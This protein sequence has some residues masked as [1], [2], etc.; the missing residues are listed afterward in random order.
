MAERLLHARMREAAVAHVTGSSGQLPSSRVGRDD[1]H[2]LGDNVVYMD[3]LSEPAS[4]PDANKAMDEQARMNANEKEAAKKKKRD[5]WHKDPYALPELQ[6]DLNKITAQNSAAAV[7]G[8]RGGIRPDVRFATEGE[9]RSLLSSIQPTDLDLDSEFF[10]SLPAELQYELVGDLRAASRGTSY[11]RLQTMLAQ[12]PT[13]IDFSRAQ[14]AGLKTRNELTQKV[15]EV[16]DE[17]GDAHIKV[18]IRVAGAR[19]REYVLVR[20]KGDQ[21]G[22]VLGIREHGNTKEKPISVDDDSVSAISTDDDDFAKRDT[23]DEIELEEID[24]QESPQKRPNQAMSEFHQANPN[25]P[26]A[27]RKVAH[28]LLQRRARELAREKSREQGVV[29]EGEILEEQWRRVQEAQ[30][31]DADEAQVKGVDSLFLTIAKTAQDQHT[32]PDADRDSDIEMEEPRLSPSQYAMHLGPDISDTQSTSADNESDSEIDYPAPRSSQQSVP[33]SSVVEDDIELDEVDTNRFNAND[34]RDFHI[35]KVPSTREEE[36]SWMKGNRIKNSDPSIKEASPTRATKHG[37]ALGFRLSDREGYPERL[38]PKL[39][40]K[41]RWEE[42]DANE[43]EKDRKEESKP[44]DAQFDSKDTQ[45]E[46]QFQDGSLSPL[47]QLEEE[48]KS[49]KSSPIVHLDE[50]D[51]K[52]DPSSPIVLL[53]EKE[54]KHSSPRTPMPNSPEKHKHSVLLHDHSP[55]TIRSSQDITDRAGNEVKIV[56]YRD[57]ANPEENGGNMS[58]DALDSGDDTLQGT[59]MKS[60]LHEG[61]QQSATEDDEK[62]H[63]EAEK[64]AVESDGELSA[65]TS[66][67]L[68]VI[69]IDEK[70][71][72]NEDEVGRHGMDAVSPGPSIRSP[73]FDTLSSIEKDEGHVPDIEAEDITHETVG[74]EEDLDASDA[75]SSPEPDV[76]LGPDGFPLPSAEELDKMVAQDE[77]ELGELDGDQDEFISFLSRA[78]G[79]GLREVREEV[80]QEVN[81]LRTEHAATR[82]TEGDITQQMAKEIQLMLRLFGLPYIT[83][84]MEAEAQCAEL[85]GIGLADGIITDDSDVFLFGGTFVYKNM[86]NN[87]KYVECYKLSD[88]QHDLGMDRTKLVQ[89]AYLLGSD[90]TDGLEGVGP[91]LAMEILSN[92][93]GDDALIQF[94]D[95]WLKI[96]TGQDA[97]MDV[98]NSTLKRLKRTLRNK[99]HFDSQWPDATVLD[100]YYEPTVDSSDE[101]FQ[102][103]LPDLDSLRSFFFEYLRWDREKTDHYLLPAIEEQNRRSRRTQATLDHGNFFDLSEGQG[104]YAGRARPG[105]NSA[106]LRQVLQNFRTSQAAASHT[107]THGGQG[108]EAVAISDDDDHFTPEHVLGK[109]MGNTSRPI[110]RREPNT[111]SQHETSHQTAQKQSSTTSK[112]SKRSRTHQD[113]PTVDEQEWRPRNA[114]PKR[115]KSSSRGGMSLSQGRTMSLDKVPSLPPSRVSA[116]RKNGPQQQRSSDEVVRDEETELSS[117]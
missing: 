50:K 80:E 108:Q 23:D 86:F 53:E 28:E 95:W 43:G 52:Q 45:D 56:D 12:S 82:R 98:S 75:S 55:I 26:Q 47:I 115:Q 117:G 116:R 9:L 41:V 81:Q 44:R 16:T 6:S 29:D 4:V 63:T 61:L 33:A 36:P 70:Q 5:Q 62:T 42:D 72:T 88:L 54:S 94:R 8:R 24:I 104:A 99:V 85:V 92:F 112:Q 87:K 21:A 96:Q 58:N 22:F 59:E 74:N 60:P 89:L 93:K 105:Y 110:V 68:G 27:R 66:P 39:L 77:A 100:A 49:G 1:G 46:E 10:R 101:P 71:T 76:V 2:G 7:K 109:Q 107:H 3:E 83:A 40:A 84:P 35:S 19:N 113:A 48:P 17:I 25:D 65:P 57:E 30:R 103:G 51:L 34:Y 69:D 97:P 37:P 73:S 114:R 38:N 79:R 13:P 91:V 14:I 20:N 15:L 111:V 102:W 67:S 64:V 11:K 78:K 106:R 18:P 31:T 90:Y 32:S